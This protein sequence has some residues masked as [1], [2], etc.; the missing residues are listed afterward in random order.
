MCLLEDSDKLNN[1]AFLDTLH[2]KPLLKCLR[3]KIALFFFSFSQILHD[4]LSPACENVKVGLRETTQ[5]TSTHL[6]CKTLVAEGREQMTPLQDQW[7]HD[8]RPASTP[9]PSKSVEV[10]VTSPES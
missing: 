2:T 4:L 10:N 9:P 1:Y 7:Q 6:R 3:F 5:N 8:T